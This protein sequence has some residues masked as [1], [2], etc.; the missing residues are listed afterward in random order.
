[1]END[2]ISRSD[3]IKLVTFRYENPEICTKEINEIP[4]VAAMPVVHGRY[5][6]PF[7][8]SDWR[9]QM[10]YSK[11]SVCGWQS[12]GVH[13]DYHFCPHCGAKMDGKD[14]MK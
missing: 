2:L 10:G 6:N 3:V 7:L 9:Y 4:A 14:D 8:K 1:M 5:E 13:D 11:C 12:I